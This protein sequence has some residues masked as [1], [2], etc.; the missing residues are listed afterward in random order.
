MY[1]SKKALVGLNTFALI[2]LLSVALVFF[3]YYFYIESARDYKELNSLNECQNILLNFRSELLNLITHSNST[4]TY[5]NTLVEQNY[6]ITIQSTQI[7]CEHD[8]DF[9]IVSSDLTNFGIEF[10]EEYNFYPLQANT[11]HFNSTCISLI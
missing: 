3:T 1:H 10:C 6:L 11:F 8:T 4:I 2:V 9:S 7:L 5:Q